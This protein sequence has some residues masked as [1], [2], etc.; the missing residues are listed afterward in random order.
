MSKWL[1]YSLIFFLPLLMLGCNKRFDEP[2]TEMA[3]D[4][5]AN[6]TIQELRSMHFTG[7]FE[8][9][10]NEW[11]IGGTVIANDREDNFY[12]SIIIQDS[13]GGITIRMDGFGLYNDYPIGIKVFI[14]LKDLWL[15]DYARMIQLGAGVD[16]SDSAYPQ[17]I[18]IP[19]PLFERFIV[20]G[21]RMDSVLPIK[22]RFDQLNDDFQSRLITIADAEFV[23]ADTGKTYADGINK[24]SVN[25]I[26]K[27]C[28][29]GSAFL[30]TSGFANF[31]KIKT[32][33]GNGALTAIYSVFNTEKQLLI[34]DTAD[35]QL[36]GL[37]CTGTGSKLLFSEDF[38]IATPNKSIALSGWKNIAELGAKTFF[39][40]TAENNRYAEISGFATGQTT[41]ISWLIT[42][43][44]NLSNASNEI[45]TFYTKDGFDNGGILQVYVSTN[46]DGGNT[47]WK[48][49]WTL[50]KPNISKGSVTAIAGSWFFS[51]NISLNSFTGN[52]YIAFRYDGADPINPNDK[53]TTSFQIDNVKIEGN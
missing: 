49:K 12:K 33:R 5:Q 25:H 42:P 7:N 44:I 36:N 9:I 20:K 43:P 40:K 2:P 37:R 26:I 11:I 39:A 28:N 18:G 16:R 51:G 15:G 50:V 30:R 1:H 17:L 24:L 53:R 6:L 45:L 3:N 46:Y 29:G 35:V 14:R 19:V 52:A 27:S 10:N 22:I 21:N 41:I 31:A 23:T 34:R 4:M 8:K 38:E 32:P 13:T 48:A 47:P